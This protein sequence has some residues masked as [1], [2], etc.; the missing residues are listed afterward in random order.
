VPSDLGPAEAEVAISRLVELTAILTRRASQLQ[1]A[2]DSR[3]VIEQ[4]KGILAERYDLSVD[5]AFRI[6]R[7]AARS[8][9]V[10]LHDLATRVVESPVT[11]G[12]IRTP[13]LDGR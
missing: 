3:V 2:L 7:R 13:S 12:E 6:L 4:A 5:Q 11:P 9:R 1:H 8:N 10:P